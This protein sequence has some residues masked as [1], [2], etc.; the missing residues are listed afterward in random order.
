M[1]GVLCLLCACV[2]GLT[3]D[4]PLNRND[5]RHNSVHHQLGHQA[6]L[7]MV[8]AF[9]FPFLVLSKKSLNVCFVALQIGAWANPLAYILQCVS[10]QGMPMDM[11]SKVVDGVPATGMR[12]ESLNVATGTTRGVFGSVAQCLLVLGCAPGMFIGISMLLLGL[13]RNRDWG[14][15]I[16]QLQDDKKDE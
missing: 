12:A 7:L 16:R 3:R 4:S 1:S 9:A 8:L 15:S 2:W 5:R 14:A 13:I 6:E 10:N 11:D